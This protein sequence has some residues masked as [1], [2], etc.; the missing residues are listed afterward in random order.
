[1]AHSRKADPEQQHID[2]CLNILGIRAR[3]TSGQLIAKGNGEWAPI[4]PKR[5]LPIHIPKDHAELHEIGAD[6]LRLTAWQ[7]AQEHSGTDIR[8]VLSQQLPF[9]VALRGDI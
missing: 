4:G 6:T 8:E 5:D 3:E 1:M 9:S 7:Y 2:Y